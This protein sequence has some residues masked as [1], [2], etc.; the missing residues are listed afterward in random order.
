MHLLMVSM[1]LMSTLRIINYVAVVDKLPN[2][3]HRLKGGIFFV[4][5]F[6]KTSTGKIKKNELLLILIA[7][8]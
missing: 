3:F 1:C 7:F 5:S 8:K 4:D 2:E 6:P